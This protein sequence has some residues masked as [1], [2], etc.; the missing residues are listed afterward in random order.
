MLP[1]SA[2]MSDDAGNYVYVVGKDDKVVRRNV[3]TG[4]VTDRGIAIASGLTGQER[5]V[6][7][8]GAFLNPGEKVKP[9]LGKIE[10]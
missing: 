7:R 4:L 6:M 5:V 1:E 10:R 8:A 9:K 2:V 3:T